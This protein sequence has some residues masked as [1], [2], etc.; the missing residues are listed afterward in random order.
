MT[1]PRADVA[2]RGL[3]QARR[4]RGKAWCN[5]GLRRHV[6]GFGNACSTCRNFW[7]RV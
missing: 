3:N 6:S 5:T 1:S 2:S 4:A 7:W